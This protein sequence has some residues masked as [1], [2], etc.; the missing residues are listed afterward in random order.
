MCTHACK[1]KFRELLLLNACH[2]KSKVGTTILTSLLSSLLQHTT[3]WQWYAKC[4]TN[5]LLRWA[6]ASPTLV[7]TWNGGSCSKNCSE[8]WDYNTLLQFG[9]VVYVQTN[10]INL[11][12]LPYKCWVR[13]F[14]SRWVRV[15]DNNELSLLTLHISL[16]RSFMWY[17]LLHCHM[18][19]ERARERGKTQM[20]EGTV[21]TEW[22]VRNQR[23]MIN[24]TTIIGWHE[25]WTP[26]KLGDQQIKNDTFGIERHQGMSLSKVYTWSPFIIQLKFYLLYTAQNNSW[27]STGTV[28]QP[29][30]C[31]TMLQ[32]LS[33]CLVWHWLRFGGC[34]L[35]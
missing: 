35:Q 30:A 12:I 29:Q 5:F 18:K 3:F 8:K 1:L 32:A 2:T 13:L 16:L 33:I 23:A 21:I 28:L 9:T 20:T 15:T 26:S 17:C 4:K 11:R 34:F 31:P 6:W 14:V 19:T 24:D 27:C 25:Q 10:M 7:G 22:A